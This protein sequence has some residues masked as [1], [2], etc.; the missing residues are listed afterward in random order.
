MAVVLPT[1]Q[2]DDLRRVASEAVEPFDHLEGLLECEVN[3]ATLSGVRSFGEENLH[4]QVLIVLMEPGPLWPAGLAPVV[5]VTGGLII[6]GTRG[7]VV[8]GA[9]LLGWHREDEETE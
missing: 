4:D 1:D 2:V 3:F 9:R 7:R 5:V 6:R 8:A